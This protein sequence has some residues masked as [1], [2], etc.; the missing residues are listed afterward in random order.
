MNVLRRYGSMM[1]HEQ[2][3][4]R[5]QCPQCGALMVEADR[6]R[7]EGGVYVWYVC[8]KQDCNGQWLSKN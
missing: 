5:Q 7:E 3:Q 4:T 6:L 8:S 1:E 2:A